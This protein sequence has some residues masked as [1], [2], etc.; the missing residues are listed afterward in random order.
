MKGNKKMQNTEKLQNM[1]REKKLQ[2]LSQSK[3]VMEEID[4][5]EDL[6]F[7]IERLQEKEHDFKEFNDIKK[8]IN[9]IT[10]TVI[11]MS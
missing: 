2:L 9:I 3:N 4:S 10:I 11:K 1:I 8:Q 5:L 7:I 6:V